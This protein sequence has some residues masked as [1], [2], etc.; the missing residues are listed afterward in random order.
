[1]EEPK[2]ADAVSIPAGLS[3]RA[4]NPPPAPGDAEADDYREI[5]ERLARAVARACP[6]WLAGQY[7]DIV[8]AAVMRVMEVRRK[9][10]GNH[11]YPSS[12]L[13]RVAYSATVDEIRRLQSRKETPM[14]DFHAERLESA[15][16]SDPERQRSAREIAEGIRGCLARLV[17][18]RRLAV[19]LHLQGH[20]VRDA[21]GLLGW[22]AKRVEN[23]VYRGLGDLRRCLAAKGLKP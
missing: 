3:R 8:Q 14:E 6:G 13:W 12:Y 16:A 2:R 20:S 21:S 23:L 17:R 11:A 10:E 22:S 9:G 19:M 4:V 15:V 18:P 1:M 7:E 5:R